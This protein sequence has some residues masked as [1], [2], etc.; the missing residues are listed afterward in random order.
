MQRKVREAYF[1]YMHRHAGSGY[2]A[3]NRFSTSGVSVSVKR[4]GMEKDPISR[5]AV[6]HE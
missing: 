6:K 1:T 4:P 2:G 5:F 3:Q